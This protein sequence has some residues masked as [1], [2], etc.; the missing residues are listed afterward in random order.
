MYSKKD[1]RI[2]RWLE[3]F[4]EP[5]LY[6]GI[7]GDLDELYEYEAESK[8]QRKAK[9]L[10]NLRA[11]GFFR[12]TFYKKS[13]QYHSNWTTMWRHYL[14]IT[15]R[16]LK[17][18]K[19]YSIIN[20]LGLTIG[21]TAGFM[22]L[23]YVFYENTYDQFFDNKENIYR[24]R[25]DRFENGKIATQWA[26]GA[27]GAGI[28]LAE[29]FPEVL[30]YVKLCGFGDLLVKDR[31][32]FN[33][34]HG[35]FATANFFE[36][37]SIPLLKGNKS[38]ALKELNKIVL[39]ES[40]TSRIFGEQDPMGK[41]ILTNN[42][43]RFIVTGVFEDL[44]EK[45]HLAIDLL[46]SMETR[47]SWMG[48]ERDQGNRTWD[49]DGWT[50]YI[51][52]Q[53]G[54]SA[55]ELQA[56]IPEF[57]QRHE[58]PDEIDYVASINFVLQP[59]TDIHLTS[60]YR[61]EIKPTGDA[62]AVNFLLIVGLFVLIIAWINYINLTTAR[63]LSRAKEVGVRKVLGSHRGQLMRQFLFESIFTN[64][65]AFVLTAA[66]VLISLPYFS[67]FVDR[68]SAYTWPDQ[69]WFWFGM[70]TLLLGGTLLSGFYPALVLSGFKPIKVL[71]GKFSN[72]GSGNLMRKG[73]VIAQFLASIILITGTFIVYQQMSFLRNQQL[74][75]DLE[76]TV[77]LES[78][79]HYSDS[80]NVPPYRVFKNLIESEI[81]ILGLSSS[82][83]VPGGSPGW[84][85]GGIKLIHQ[86]DDESTQ[87]RVIGM[88]DQFKDLF[89]LEVIAGRGF[90]NSFGNE[91]ENILCNETALRQ[92]GFSN[93]DSILNQKVY[94]WGDTFNV[95]G[96]IKDYR[97][98]SPKAKYDAL[99]FRYFDTP[100]NY[101]SI[102]VKS[103]NMRATLDRLEGHWHQAFGD[104]PF[105]YFFVDDHYNDQ[106]KAELRFGS[107]FGMFSGL[108]IFVACLGLFGLASYMTSL[109]MKEVSIRKVLGAS[110]PQLW[111]LLTRDFVKLVT[112]SIAVAILPTWY[113][114]NGWLDNFA[115][116]ISLSWWLFLVPALVLL[117]IS[118]A[119]VSYQTIYTVNANPAHTL[120]DE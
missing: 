83:T 38:T 21:M 84:N 17:R 108:A 59:L 61:A 32:F 100:L 103:N 73:L 96:V 15:I 75:V 33:Y 28:E 86:S 87:Y 104:K 112:I 118:I 49:W 24:V 26:S 68:S 47:L 105:T 107:I 5:W 13:K 43:T 120:Q 7:R 39:S 30:D 89:N 29:E 35:F 90:D 109:R 101:Y 94:F 20:L 44:P 48:E 97:Q 58:A 119:T 116:R 62:T 60:D 78:Y 2:D 57:V 55:D 113:I 93:A 106:Y 3:W 117:L 22:I 110:A 46:A 114:M 92:F 52:L 27:S 34:E 8:G 41:E 18:Q 31:N 23:Q 50:N 51:V 98:E 70:I 91:H 66:L 42:G 95:V 77:V 37:F 6:E 12:V 64:I 111:V 11:I 1:F 9:W 102:K 85:A 99:L 4:C 36:V 45:S 115:N 40:M 74:G 76:Q 19:A 14:T 80:I 72:S 88:D 81:E 69:S 53:N 10:Y 79:K 16:N 82:T 65:I 54:N 56:K 63:S 25:T 71:K 67:E